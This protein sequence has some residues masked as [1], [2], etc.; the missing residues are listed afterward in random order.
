METKK[1]FIVLAAALTLDELTLIERALWAEMETHLM[2]SID[3]ME[4]WS[5]LQKKVHDARTW[6]IANKK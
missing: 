2:V 6:L 1:H 3:Q 5:E 4:E